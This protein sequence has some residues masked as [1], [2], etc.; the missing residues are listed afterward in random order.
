M[1]RAVLVLCVTALLAAAPAGARDRLDVL[2]QQLHE[3]QAQLAELKAQG[4][5]RSAALA[6]AKHDTDAHYADLK[7][8]LGKDAAA[9]FDHGRLTFVSPDGAFSLALRATV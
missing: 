6:Q 4:K 2:E 3:A 5:D 1:R 9:S 8:R 7:V